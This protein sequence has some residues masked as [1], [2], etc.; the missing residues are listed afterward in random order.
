MNSSFFFPSKY[1][2]MVRIS[3]RDLG[4]NIYILEGK[5][6]LKWE[7]KS[8][9][10]FEESM[11]M[12]ASMD[13]NKKICATGKSDKISEEKGCLCGGCPVTSKMGLRWNYYCTRGSGR[14]QMAAEKK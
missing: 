12:M 11:E 3:S 13:A 7:V 5:N 10:S 4:I 6:N 1:L 9:V 8:M 14:E 2:A